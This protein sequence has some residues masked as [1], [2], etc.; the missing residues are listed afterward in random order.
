[1][2]ATEQLKEEHK[3]I[4]LALKIFEKI[5]KNIKKREE[6]DKK[7]LA[8][9]L[10]FLKV[11]VDKCHH[12]KE[13]DV[14]FPSMEKAGIPNEGGP[15]GMMLIEHKAGKEYI[16][17]FSLALEKFKKGDKKSLGVIER[18]LKSYIDL[19]NEHIEKENNI[20]YPI[21]DMHIL[22]KEQN[23]L[24]EKFEKIEKEKIG[25]GKHE[26]F[27]KMLGELKRFYKIN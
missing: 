20:L 25:K 2:S 15:I 16:K 8:D 3:S 24:V 9:L 13:E 22:S 26:Q 5:I 14:L 4:K 11:F 10:D 6:P 21:A 19:L 27:H 17:G 18:N 23:K 1:M 12:A 7:H